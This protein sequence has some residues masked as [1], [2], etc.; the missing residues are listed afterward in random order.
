MKRS[1][2]LVYLCVNKFYILISQLLI[3]GIISVITSGIAETATYYMPDNFPDLK[4]AFAGMSGGDT[5]IIR[6]GTYIG[7]K[8]RV[9]ATIKPPVGTPANY[10]VIKAEHPGKVI[11]GEA[12]ATSTTCDIYSEGNSLYYRFEGIIWR[13][14]VQIYNSKYV[15]MIQCGAVIISPTTVEPG[16]SADHGSEYILFED[17]FAWGAGKYRFLAYKASKI[18]MRRCVARLDAVHVNDPI[19]GFALY[20]SSDCEV[21]DCIVIDS[22]A[23]E[24]WYYEDGMAGCFACPNNGVPGDNL[25]FRGC[26]SLNNALTFGEIGTL[27]KNVY[28]INCVGWHT[29]HGGMSRGQQVSLD[30]CVFG[31]FYGNDSTCY[32]AFHSY[33]GIGSIKNSIVYNCQN[34]GAFRLVELSDYNC[35]YKN[36]TNY[37]ATT[38]GLHDITNIDPIDG[39]PGNGKP[40]LKYLCRVE[41]GS[42]LDGA[43]DDG[44]DIG[45][46]ILTKIG[47]SGTLWGEPGYN[48]DTGESLWPFP[49]ED[50]IREHMRSYNPGRTDPTKPDGKRGFCADGTT[51]TKYIWEYLGNPTPPEFSPPAAPKNLRIIEAK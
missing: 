40:A 16:F 9:T 39:D 8:N 37:L 12:D 34:N 18:I 25:Y 51:L 17:C 30:H 44:G 32:A 43:A 14:G 50:Q 4:T 42:N 11:V 35:L 24:T 6:D 1:Q 21:Q 19:G 2:N 23:P 29:I 33:E 45:A 20:Y 36:K 38:P 28:R 5:L 47:V 27:Y 22:D 31:D 49:L 7:D 48:T 13:A 10:T 26:I 41:D 3:I 15:K 46:T